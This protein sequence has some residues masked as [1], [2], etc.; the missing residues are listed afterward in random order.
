MWV[1]VINLLRSPTNKI[2]AEWYTLLL[3]KASTLSFLP[4]WL[5]P[6]FLGYRLTV[7]CLECCSRCRVST[8]IDKP[9]GSDPRIRM[10]GLSKQL[11]HTL[12]SASTANQGGEGDIH[13]GRARWE[14]FSLK[15]F[16]LP[17]IFQQG[18]GI[19]QCHLKNIIYE[20]IEFIEK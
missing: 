3:S 10:T 20:R 6:L 16:S 18:R 19:I 5:L 12:T 9:Q 17:S 11:W 7:Q 15:Y 13:L 4:L 8:I 2:S 1:L 14:V